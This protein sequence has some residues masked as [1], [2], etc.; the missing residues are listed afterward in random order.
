MTNEAIFLKEKLIPAL[1][2]IAPD[3][4]GN[5]GVMSPQQMVEHF[6]DS[7][8][9]A[10]G[11]LVLPYV[12][13]PERKEAMH[14]FLMSDIPFKENTKNP[15]MPETPH[16]PRFS[17]LEEAIEKLQKRIDIFFETFEKN[18]TLTT[19]NPVF[20][21]LN[22]EQNVHLLYKHAQHHLK[23]FGIEN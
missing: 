6:G 13:P 17:G 16:A 2:K 18:P 12:T 23:Q 14:N 4:K 20:G 10:Y 8:A 5:W 11:K 19:I 9:N 21:A 3:A 7:L 15:I 1:K 22:F